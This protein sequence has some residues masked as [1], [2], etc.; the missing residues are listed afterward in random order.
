MIGE[1]EAFFDEGVD[2]DRSMLPRTFA[3]V[4]QHILDDGVGAPAVLYDL[5]E[6][7]LQCIRQFADFAAR[8]VVGLHALQRFLQFIDQFDGNARE[9]IDEIERVLDLVGNPRSELTE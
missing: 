5:A 7:V 3:R 9:V 6:I 8:L 1:V 2:I 4:Q